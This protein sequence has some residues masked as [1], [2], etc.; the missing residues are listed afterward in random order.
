M[1]PRQVGNHQSGL[2]RISVEC[3]F[4][5]PGVGTTSGEGEGQKFAILGTLVPL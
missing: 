2:Q 5:M 3:T 4:G 1:G